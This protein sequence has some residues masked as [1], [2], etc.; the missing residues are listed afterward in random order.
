[1]TQEFHLSV[2]PVGAD[3]YLVRTEQVARG[4]PLAEEQVVWPVSDWLNRARQLYLD[5]IQ[6]W[7]ETPVL[8]NSEP[9]LPVAPGG[10]R[11]AHL[12][13]LGQQLYEALFQGT[14]RDS[15]LIAGVLAQDRGE[16]LRL[17]LG[18]KTS[19]RCLLGSTFPGSAWERGASRRHRSCLA[20]LPWEVLHDGSRPLATGTDVVFSRYHPVHI[21][22][23]NGS[24]DRELSAEPLKILM[25]IAA[26]SDRETLELEREARN[27]QAELQQANSDV[28][29]LQ[30]TILAQADREQLTQALEQGKY[31]VFH[32]AG[33]SNLGVSGGEI[34]LVSGR[35][36]L[37]E[38]LSGDDLAGLLVNNGIQVA[39]LN[40]CRSAD[41][42]AERGDGER[43]RNLA[44]TLVLLGIPGVLA[45][46]ERIPDRV[47]LTLSQLLYRNLKQGYPI[48]LSLSRA[49]QGLISAYGSH[50][51][52]WAL[53]ILYLQPGFDGCLTSNGSREW[54]CLS[55]EPED[56]LSD[57][58]ILPDGDRCAKNRTKELGL[59]QEA[60]SDKDNDLLADNNLGLTL[61]SQGP[62]HDAIGVKQLAASMS[63]GSTS[64]PGS[65]WERTTQETSP[66]NL[67]FADAH[68]NLGV[69]FY[70]KGQ[71][72]QAISSYLKAIEI[73]PD[74]ADAH[75][76]LGIAF[77]DLGRIDEAIAAYQQ[78]LFIDPLHGN[79]NYNLA[80]LSGSPLSVAAPTKTR[81]LKAEQLSA[82]LESGNE[83]LS[84]EQISIESKFLKW[85]CLGMGV[86]ALF[87]FFGLFRWQ[88]SSRLDP[89][90]PY[91]EPTPETSNAN[92]DSSNDNI[93]ITDRAAQL[94]REGKI[95]LGSTEVEKLLDSG[96]LNFA[97]TAIAAVPKDQ[98]NHSRISYLRGRLAWQQIQQGNSN[99]SL[100]DVRRFWEWA[101][102]QEGDN[103]IYYNA[104]G[105]AYYALGN[106]DAAYSSW[107]QVLELIKNSQLPDQKTQEVCPVNQDGL[108]A[109]A[110]LALVLFK[111][112]Q[113]LPPDQQ[114]PLGDRA[115]SLHQQVIQADPTNF[116]PLVLAKNNWLWTETA[117]ADWRA[118]FVENEN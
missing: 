90:P 54:D 6:G 11:P 65:A 39:V 72:E 14:I 112:A 114:D 8:S 31:D 109:C 13:S 116:Q 81:D 66:A 63:P 77:Y 27:L 23:F 100:D 80:R 69:A 5:P 85:L 107:I 82:V 96:V 79:A 59:Y 84:Q 29:Q 91:L 106:L 62:I 50:M 4:V 36:G 30:L 43:H 70:E 94:F 89:L 98:I 52:Y 12:L 38:R 95:D 71:L 58:T 73:N 24:S 46:A 1:M 32:Y 22:S 48:D 18:L 34:Y 35:T 40:S 37:T 86:T 53:P 75:N 68:Y 47:A 117:I 16:K 57:G 17:R 7:L 10:A 108:T 20:R 64:F 3:T 88:P 103:P 104:L 45:M 105:F 26:P 41:G 102:K 2:T 92:S 51:L 9:A 115:Q 67:N 76:N 49:R 118:L 56:L 99:Y 33:H 87:L 61:Y 111:S 44:E 28:G 110:G 83:N 113:N 15:W 42:V 19:D 25:A 60:V 97:S 21:S 78:A 74:F 93:N 101:A 55:A